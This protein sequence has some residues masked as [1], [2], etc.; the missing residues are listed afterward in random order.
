MTQ[1]T[2]ILSTIPVTSDIIR[3]FVICGGYNSEFTGVGGWTCDFE[4]E[5]RYSDW[6]LMGKSRGS[7]IGR[8]RG[9]W[10]WG[11]R[12]LRQMV[13]ATAQDL[14][15]AACYMGSTCA[16]IVLWFGYSFR[17]MDLIKMASHWRESH[18]QQLLDRVQVRYDCRT[19]SCLDDIKQPVAFCV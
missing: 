16:Y 14:S 6:I 1:K 13:D 7:M 11:N 15:N 12:L 17:L 8:L 2:W 19:G 18:P 3:N 10:I 9:K 4:W 5:T